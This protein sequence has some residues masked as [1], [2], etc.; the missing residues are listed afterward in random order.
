[1]RLVG[2]WSSVVRAGSA[3]G[4]WVHGVGKDSVARIELVLD[5]RS[6]SPGE[7]ANSSRRPSSRSPATDHSGEP[8]LLA[9]AEAFPFLQQ[10]MAERNIRQRQSAVP[11]E[12]GLRR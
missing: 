1:M 11:E 9:D 2:L 5:K 10:R 3:L 6:I 4:A 7:T 8:Q 12:V